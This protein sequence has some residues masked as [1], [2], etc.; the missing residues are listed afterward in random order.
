MRV[1]S[2]KCSVKTFFAIG[3][4]VKLSVLILINISHEKSP[5]GKMS[6]SSLK[7]NLRHIIWS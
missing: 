3:R 2:G 5:A 1:A 7:N 6:C 4:A